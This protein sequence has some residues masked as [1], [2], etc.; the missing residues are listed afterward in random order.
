MTHE[1]Q[2]TAPAGRRI[3]TIRA[4]LRWFV[5]SLI[6]LVPVIGL[7]FAVSAMVGVC[8]ARKAWGT[9]WNPAGHYLLAARRIAPLGLLSSA[10]FLLLVCL[11]TPAFLR[12][13]GRCC[14]GSS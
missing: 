9:S 10:L 1:S 8:R 12:D 2:E 5:C 3:E 4:S 13:M 7:P 11:V 14:G 6:G